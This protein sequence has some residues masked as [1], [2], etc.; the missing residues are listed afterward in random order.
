MYLYLASTGQVAVVRILLVSVL[1][2]HFEIV[3]L[4][5]HPLP[6]LF[7]HQTL[8]VVL[9]SNYSIILDVSVSVLSFTINL[10][11]L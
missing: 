9:N 1:M 5:P 8:P 2:N 10:V 7:H 4:P 11:L 3:P 6:E